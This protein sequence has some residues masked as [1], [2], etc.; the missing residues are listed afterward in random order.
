MTA[1]PP[2]PT[3]SRNSCG[4]ALATLGVLVPGLVI[5]VILARAA[6]VRSLEPPSDLQDVRAALLD[7][8]EVARESDVEVTVPTWLPVISRF[9][10]SLADL[11]P[12]A[13]TALRTVRCGFIG[14]YHLADTPARDDLLGMLEVADARL[15]KRSNW[16]RMVTVLD[17]NQLIAAY[18]AAPTKPSRESIDVFVVVLDNRD[19]VVLS[20]RGYPQPL[21]DLVLQDVG[22]VRLNR[23]RL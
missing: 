9:G 21:F 15:F 4:R 18:G 12:R 19:L 22:A 11:D 10:A 20:A 3:R 14:V 6:V 2:H 1:S 5:A 8:L 13:I 17:E 7:R 16:S 23:I